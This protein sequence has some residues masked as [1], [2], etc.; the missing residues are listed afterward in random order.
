MKTLVALS[1]VLLTACS[2]GGSTE[3]DNNW[4]E[5][6][7]DPEGRMYVTW[8]QVDQ[9]YVDVQACVG[10]SAE[11]PTIVWESFALNGSIAAMGSYLHTTQTVK[12]NTDDPIGRR[13]C[14]TDEY[15]LKHEFV[16]HLLSMGGFPLI[17]NIQHN[18]LLFGVCR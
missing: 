17:D 4:C 8:A 6:T 18:S 2:G 7:K 9:F 13:D 10:I 14:V 1:F 5:T 16:H 11:V 15:T 12:V 3:P